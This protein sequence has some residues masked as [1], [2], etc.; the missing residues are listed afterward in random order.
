MVSSPVLLLISLFP[1]SCFAVD[2]LVSL[3]LVMSWSVH[4]LLFFCFPPFYLLKAYF[5]NSLYE[6]LVF[7]LYPCLP[8][9]CNHI[10]I[11]PVYSPSCLFFCHE[12]KYPSQYR[13]DIH[14][15]LIK[16]QLKVKHLFLLLPPPWI[17]TQGYL[18]PVFQFSCRLNKILPVHMQF[19]RGKWTYLKNVF[20][21]FGQS[22]HCTLLLHLFHE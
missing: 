9:M 21:V 20:W 2:K 11:I 15:F 10:F 17:R 3:H 12:G 1:F 4:I 13:C 6:N 19:W 7:C 5:L 8:C 16:D 14:T 18:N 22:N